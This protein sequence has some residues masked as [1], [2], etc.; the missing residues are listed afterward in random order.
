MSA[1]SRLSTRWR[2][3]F[4]WWRERRWKQ[5]APNFVRFRFLAVVRANYCRGRF[6]PFVNSLASDWLRLSPIFERHGNISR[7]WGQLEPDAARILL[8]G[9]FTHM[10]GVHISTR[11]RLRHGVDICLD[12][13][14][15][16]DLYLPG[17][18][19]EY[20]WINWY[21]FQ[22]DEKLHNDLFYMWLERALTTGWRKDNWRLSE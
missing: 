14:V 22:V 10:A 17:G 18:I 12:I 3:I 4:V 16:I 11:H 13:W 19:W 2:H 5:R 1:H 8:H 15:D 6:G 9:I 20:V 7:G 21:I